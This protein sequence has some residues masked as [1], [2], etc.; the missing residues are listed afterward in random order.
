MHTDQKGFIKGRSISELIRYIDD[1]I[2]TTRYN[3]I[4][5]LI[6][7]VDFRKAFDSISKNTIL[8]ALGKF[9]FGPTMVKLVSVLL[10][11]TE[12]CVR[13]YNWFSSF[14]PCEK[15][16]GQGCCASPYLFLLV[17]ELLSIRLRGS[18]EISGI[19]IPNTNIHINK[20]LQYADDT[21][22]FLK[23]EH[24]L[25]SAL[26]IIESF[27]TVSGLKLNRQK[28][29]ALPLGGYICTDPSTTNVKWLKPNEYIKILGVY[30][31]AD[32]EASTIE[33]NWKSKIDS[34]LRLVN[35]WNKRN[36]SMYGKIILCKTF[37]LAKINYLIQSL[38]LPEQ[39]LSEIDKIMFTFIWHKKTSKKRV[40]ERINRNMMYQDIQ[41]GGLKMI[42]V[43]D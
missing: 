13:N 9:C 40:V 20:I 10:K 19:S 7:S 23:D 4:S 29:T 25:E 35:N 6:V 38:S 42:S 5:G 32:K 31:S 39:V 33:L 43:K 34:I 14:F 3:H 41:L 37:I 21:S 24:E 36:I 15:G 27:S 1:S 28:S 2:L 12:S 18:S 16:V 30:F 22:L 8:N 17:A 11:N 26:S